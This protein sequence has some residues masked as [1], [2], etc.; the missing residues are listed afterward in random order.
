MLTAIIIIVVV[1]VLVLIAVR[2]LMPRMRE[3]NRIRQREAELGQRREQV[4]E[5][6]RSEAQIREQRAEEAEHRA[7]IAAQEAQRERADAQLQKEQAAL[8]ERGMADDQLI[9][10]HEREQ[11]AGTSAVP[12]GAADGRADGGAERERTT[13]YDEG[14]RAAHD[15]TRAEDFQEGQLRERE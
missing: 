10:D 12:G 3:R 5:E 2:L 4:V 11:F 6:H 8:H 15:P 14:R 9:A 13:A 1:V 7:R